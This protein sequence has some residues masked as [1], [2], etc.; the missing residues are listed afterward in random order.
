MWVI[1]GVFAF[2]AI[3]GLITWAAENSE[4]R[5]N[6][7][8]TK[9][10]GEFYDISPGTQSL[11]TGRNIPSYTA[12]VN[13]VTPGGVRVRQGRCCARGH[14]SPETAVQHASIIK[15]RIERTGR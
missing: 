12:P 6:G 8:P 7:Q 2:F 4:R 14:Q 10:L 5:K 3:I 1:V 15:A 9:R 11:L 13:A